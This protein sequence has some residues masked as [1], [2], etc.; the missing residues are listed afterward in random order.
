M[1]SVDKLSRVADIEKPIGI[2][3]Y[4]FFRALPEPLGTIL[5]SIEEIEA[6]LSRDLDGMD[7]P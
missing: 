4:Q 1:S 3:E 2:A 6:E 5:P 7:Q